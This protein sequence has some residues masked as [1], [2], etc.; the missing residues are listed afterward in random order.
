[1]S[2][3]VQRD[4]RPRVAPLAPAR[5]SR[6]ELQRT[7]QLERDREDTVCSK[8]LPASTQRRG[9]VSGGGLAGGDTAAQLVCRVASGATLTLTLTLLL[10]LTLTLV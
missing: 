4:H 10:T 9:R 6:E 2:G 3:N 7:R 5:D 8:R 1:M